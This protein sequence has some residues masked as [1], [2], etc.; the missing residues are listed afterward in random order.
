M[1]AAI[2]IPL[3][4]DDLNE[5]PKRRIGDTRVLCGATGRDLDE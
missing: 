2:A 3:R 4:L 5:S 1:P